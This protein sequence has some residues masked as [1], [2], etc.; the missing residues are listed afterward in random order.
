MAQGRFMVRAAHESKLMR[1]IHLL[2]HLKD[3]EIDLVLQAG[4][5]LEGGPRRPKCYSM[6]LQLPGTNTSQSVRIEE[7]ELINRGIRITYMFLRESRKWP[8]SQSVM[9]SD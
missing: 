4:K 1:G 7:R 8:P 9:P 5:V 3:Q 6:Q 2:G